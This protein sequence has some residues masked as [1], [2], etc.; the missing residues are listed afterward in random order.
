MGLRFPCDP[1]LPSTLEKFSVKI[2]QLAPNS[3][4]EISKLF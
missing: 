4:L 2:H 1:V 3:F